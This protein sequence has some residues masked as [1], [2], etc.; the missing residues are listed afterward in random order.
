MS[1]ALRVD[2]VVTSGTFS[3]DGG[4][5]DVDNNIWLIGDDSEVVVVDAA[6]TAQPIIDAVAGRRVKAIVLTHGHNDHVTVAPELSE[7]L[8]APILL[9]PADDV[10][11]RMTHPDVA[12]LPLE[13]GQRIA[14]AG[15]EIQAIHTPGHSPGSTCLYLPEAGELFSGDTLFSGGPGATGRSFSDFP[16]IIGSIRD[17]LFAL[18]AETRV[19]T[20][21]GDGTTIG[22]ESPHLEEWIRAGS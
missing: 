14:V 18:P 22:T 20:G 3:L 13:D 1:G 15:T 19:H 7:R 16:T 8:D 4:T 11:W 6:H 10:L 21:H 12:H 17:R 9:H 5:W 2:R